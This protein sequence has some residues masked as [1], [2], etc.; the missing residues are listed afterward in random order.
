LGIDG[1][2]KVAAQ[3]LSA[4]SCNQC[5]LAGDHIHPQHYFLNDEIQVPGS[6]DRNVP[7]RGSE[8]G[9]GGQ[10]IDGKPPPATEEM[11]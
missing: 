6:I 7:R 5:H 8:T 11:E 10:D 2:P 1:W 9:G 3:P 4:V